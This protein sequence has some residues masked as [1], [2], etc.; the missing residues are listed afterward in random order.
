ME[1]YQIE[2]KVSCCNRENI[3][4]YFNTV[5]MM[6]KGFGL[7]LEES[8]CVVPVVAVP[9]PVMKE[10]QERSKKEYLNKDEVADFL[11]VKKNTVYHWVH[12]RK[13]PFYKMGSRTMFRITE[14]D[15]WIEK[16]R[17]KAIG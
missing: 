12:S 3:N 1:T 4:S 9:V 13:I 5:L 7:S 15:A 11:G 10:K 16:T 17:K 8:R 6:A 14:L 2:L